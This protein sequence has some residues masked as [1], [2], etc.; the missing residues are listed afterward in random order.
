[1]PKAR[2]ATV[3]VEALHAPPPVGCEASSFTTIPVGTPGVSVLLIRSLRDDSESSPFIVTRQVQQETSCSSG[4][5][6]YTF[7]QM[8]PFCVGNA[9][10]EL[11]PVLVMLTTESPTLRLEE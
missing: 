1:M 5:N 8:F 11:F 6:V 7:A 3:T 9:I 2:F 10:V 4:E